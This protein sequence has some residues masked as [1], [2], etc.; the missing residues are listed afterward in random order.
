MSQKCCNV[1]IIWGTIQQLWMLFVEKPLWIV[2][3][4][5]RLILSNCYSLNPMSLGKAWILFCLELLV[6]NWANWVLQPWLGNQSRRNWPCITHSAHGG[7]VRYMHESFYAVSFTLGFFFLFTYSSDLKR[8]FNQC[9][10]ITD[11]HHLKSIDKLKFW[12]MW[13]WFMLFKADWLILIER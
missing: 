11:G 5:A 12:S 6:N 13:K 2:R 8:F 10:N 4:W 3:C 7:G 1:L 9:S